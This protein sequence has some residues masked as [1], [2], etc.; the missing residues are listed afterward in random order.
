MLSKLYPFGIALLSAQAQAQAPTPTSPLESLVRGVQSAVETGRDTV[1]RAQ[2]IARLATDR[3][4]AQLALAT[5]DRFTYRYAEAER[6][7]DALARDPTLAH[8]LRIYADLGRASLRLQQ[9]RLV[10]AEPIVRSTLR[11]IDSLGAPTG[12]SAVRAQLLMSLAVIVTR[13]VSVDSAIAVFSLA[14][15]AV[16]TGDA[17]LGTLVACNAFV[18]RVRI[19]EPGAAAQTRAASGAALRAGNPRAAAACLAA[20]AQ[21]QERRT[22]MDSA[23]AT[24]EEVVA[25]QRAARNLGSLAVS[26]QWQG[27]IL[28][29]RGRA[30][31]ARA[32]LDEA[33][34]LGERTGNAAAA[35]WAA[36][37][38]ADLALTFGDLASAG[39]YA[40]AAS[41]RFTAMGD[42]SGLM[43]ARQHQGD[44]AL[45]NR[46]LPAARAAYTDVRNSA[47]ALFPSAAVHARGRLATV[48]MFAGDWDGAEREFT[49]ARIDAARLDM[50]EWR[51]EDG[52]G[53]A[54]LAL[55]RDRYDE[56]T[57][58]FDAL[59][60]TLPAGQDG[61]RSDVFT[62]L[63]EAHA[64][65][66][67]FDAA[68]LALARAAVLAAQRRALLRDRDQQAAALQVR[69]YDW[70]RD[71]G[72]ATTIAALVTA[73]RVEPALRL[74]ERRRS[75]LLLEAL[76]RREVFASRAADSTR[77]A[78][79]FSESDMRRLLPE[80]T[81]VV[82]YVTGRGHEP[83][84]AFVLTR[85]TVIAVRLADVD[86]H[87]A[88]I[89]RFVGLLAAGVWP[90]AL[91]ARLGDAFVAA[92]V[93]LLPSSVTRLVIVADGVLHRVPFDALAGADGVPYVD[94][95]AISQ[96]PSIEVAATWWSAPP[97]APLPRL[98]AFGDPVGGA[99]AGLADGVAPARLPMAAMEVH[100]IARFARQ[101]NVYVGSEARESRLN[102]ASLTDVG[103]LHFATHADVEEWSLMR[104]ALALAPG[105][106][107]DGRLTTEEVLG[108]RVRANLVV[109][110]ACRSG[111][112]AVLVGEGLQGLT[113]P[114]LEAG[115]AAVVATLWQVGDR[116][117]EP[118][119]ELFYA[120]L[121]KGVGVGDALHVAKRR[122]R[123]AGMSPAV[124]A[125][126][127]LTGD[128]RVVTPLTAPSRRSALRPFGAIALLLSGGVAIYGVTIVRRRNGERR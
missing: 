8:D 79:T 124:W 96:A 93:E 121:A 105:D 67:R 75:R 12:L 94:R 125:A 35:A 87:S 54:V 61:V 40:R 102:N 81:A 85:D 31:A 7:Y 86:N 101:S 116:S 43:L 66:G 77:V 19:G 100:R 38:L 99:V 45:L 6:L 106:G 17:W 57:M 117:V 42:R 41:D 89:E 4:R 14:S 13:T 76:A 78:P 11:L 115:A 107:D 53:R 91:S 23:M 36:L 37:S 21:D 2:W 69:S 72:F 114:L 71:L 118:M 92:P 49:Q 46:S 104:S 16:P 48:A 22:Q 127:T 68:E 15:R 98:I 109:L 64:K 24:F 123:A 59:E 103:I 63:A 111:S 90:A 28:A 82:A 83:T 47:A 119:V 27:F 128:A 32:A 3:Q 108:L 30:A 110:S 62:R 65:A 10:E 26:R 60:R 74:S 39:Q 29:S 20:L 56:A 44:V 95:F 97:R 1:Q 112:G 55:A 84:T 80:S 25:L 58:R 122:A 120:E 126:F 34:A 73:K 9:A 113:I 52:Y 18:V 88:D 5:L 33:I 70:D 50:P 51:E